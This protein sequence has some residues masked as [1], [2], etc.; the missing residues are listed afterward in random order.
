MTP[1]TSQWTVEGD[2][3]GRPKALV[4]EDETGYSVVTFDKKYVWPQ[5]WDALLDLVRAAALN[6]GPDAECPRCASPDPLKHPALQFEGEVQP[7][8]DPWHTPRC[9]SCLVPEGSPHTRLCR[10]QTEG[11]TDG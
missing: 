5:H 11:T 7:C 2:G 3:E 10:E 6:G 4:W 1:P 8:P 9:G